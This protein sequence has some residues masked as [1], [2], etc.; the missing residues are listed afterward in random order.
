MKSNWTM[1]QSKRVFISD[2]SNYGSDTTAIHEECEAIKSILLGEQPKSVR[3]IVNVDGTFVNDD[4]LKEF[5][6]IIPVTN[7][8]VKRRAIIGLSGFRKNFL[9]LFTKITG[10]ANFSH[11]DTVNEALDWV[12]QD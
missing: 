12:V 2:L 10:N 5:R 3:A 4:I 7:K 9:F 6:E 8:Y 11:F 1:H